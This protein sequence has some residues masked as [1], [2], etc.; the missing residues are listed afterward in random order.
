MV[1]PESFSHG[2]RDVALLAAAAAAVVLPAGVAV[3]AAGVVVLLAAPGALLAA[4]DFMPDIGIGAYRLS[5]EQKK[6]EN[7]MNQ[8]FFIVCCF[9]E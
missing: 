7:S 5:A 4:V 1:F 3:L 2:A 9:S 6:M 8:P